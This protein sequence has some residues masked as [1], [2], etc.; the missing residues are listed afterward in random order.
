MIA[1]RCPAYSITAVGD[2]DQT[3]APHDHST[4]EGAVGAVLTERWAGGS[5]GVIAPAS[6]CS[7]TRREWPP[8]L[9]VTTGSMSP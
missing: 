3:E 7:S 9:A 6:C 2:I 8:S 1:R 4:W 5:V